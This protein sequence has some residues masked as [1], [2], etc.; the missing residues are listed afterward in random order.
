VER[1]GAQIAD[2]GVRLAKERADE[3]KANPPD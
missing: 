2:T 1:A 3:A